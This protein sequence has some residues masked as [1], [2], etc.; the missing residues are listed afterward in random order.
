MISPSGS[1]TWSEQNSAPS[2]SVWVPEVLRSPSGKSGVPAVPPGFAPPSTGDGRAHDGVT[3]F[4]EGD[5]VS[6][7]LWSLSETVPY[8]ATMLSSTFSVPS[9]A[10]Q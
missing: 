9:N 2:L 10:S 5:N 4:Q 6:T 7:R 1:S 3:V 8:S